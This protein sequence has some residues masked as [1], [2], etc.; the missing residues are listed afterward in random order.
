MTRLIRL[1][2]ALLS[3]CAPLTSVADG[4]RDYSDPG[5]HRIGVY[6][7]G[8]R[9]YFDYALAKTNLGDTFPNKKSYWSERKAAS[10]A[11]G[12]ESPHNV[13][14]IYCGVRDGATFE[15]CRRR[16]DAWLK[17][18]PG[19]PTYPETIPAI[20]L[21]EENISSRSKLMDR[22]AR[23]I[24]DNYK[25]PVF[26]WYSDPFG[27][28]TAV[29]ADGW[30]WDSYG[31]NPQR[32]RRHVMGFVLLDKPVICV[33]WATDPHW[34]QW[35]QYPS[36]AELIN[37]EWHQFSTCMEFNVSTAPFCVA[38]LGALNPWL[39]SG[40][41][42]MIHLRRALKS[43]RR[44]MH[45]LPVGTLPLASANFSEA[46]RTIPVGGDPGKPSVYVDDF[47]GTAIVHDA[48]ITGFLDLKLTSRPAEPGFLVIRPRPGHGRKSARRPV[49]VSLT[50]ELRSHFPLRRIR[51]HLDATAPRELGASNTLS[52]L[53]SGWKS[54]GV[55][56]IAE[57]TGTGDDGLVLELGPDR[58]RN[59]HG[60][61]LRIVMRQSRGDSDNLAHRLDRLVI[62]CE[63]QPP[64]AGSVAG[65]VSDDYGNLSYE[66][67]FAT[68]RWKHFG[69]LAASHPS[70]AGFRGSAF[71]VGL[72]GGFV[73]S[74]VI[75]Q[76]FHAPR[77]LKQLA[78]SVTGYANSP[79]LGG[80]IQLE[81][82]PRGGKP[83]WSTTSRG[84]HQG[85]LTL[86]VPAKELSG[87]SAK[88][89]EGIRDFDVRITLR[90]HSGVEQGDKACATLDKI[91]IRAK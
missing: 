41:P 21:E 60:A 39:G 28:S 61:L 53:P 84:R 74:N 46:S 20:C 6:A 25:I 13:Y 89:S 15:V 48:S 51:V 1:A 55:K 57:V 72:K 22:V 45:A 19:V 73:V 80:S 54:I 65:L 62:E 4:P 35:T 10:R 40:T 17:S 91:S 50:Y 67:G 77:A 79:D 37:R 52:L 90:S 69:E 24:R 86:E 18:E 82:V 70:H 66:D 44:Q 23:H 11:G 71:W 36:T 63:H 68:T 16:I 88:V 83:L 12:G 7:G 8:P 64:A 27:P 26:Q 34:P 42:D 30:I 31:W 49:D 5:Y 43:K 47:G 32:F 78:V 29:T 33:P 87:K 3:A 56:P 75:V 76:R 59:R 9:D 58:L 81:I 85:E 2:V 14:V 38:G